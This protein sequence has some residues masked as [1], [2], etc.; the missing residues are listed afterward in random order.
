[1]RR[2]VF[3]GLTGAVIALMTVFLL[4][5]LWGCMFG[6]AE[7][8]GTVSY[9]WDGGWKGVQSL[10]FLGAVFLP[11]FPGGGRWSEPQS[12]WWCGP[13]ARSRLWKQT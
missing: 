5:E 1:M 12:V 9:G 6:A 7:P 2:M 4:A 10:V 11:F 13:F 8:W 3:A